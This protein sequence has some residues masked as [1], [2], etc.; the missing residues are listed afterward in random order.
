V[1]ML[2]ACPCPLP[3]VVH[4]LPGN[5]KPVLHGIYIRA[6]PSCCAA[7]LARDRRARG[8]GPRPCLAAPVWK[9]GDRVDARVDMSARHALARHCQRKP[10]AC[11][12]A[13]CAARAGLRT[14]C[15]QRV[16]VHP[17]Q[18]ARQ[19]REP[20]LPGLKLWPPEGE[21]HH[22]CGGAGE[23]CA[24]NKPGVRTSQRRSRANQRRAP[25]P[26]AHGDRCAPRDHVPATKAASVASAARKSPMLGY[27]DHSL[28]TVPADVTGRP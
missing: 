24:N 17:R 14:L 15:R 18:P 6:I 9:L 1:H 25:A 16:S 22:R 13:A 2:C 20:N 10:A 28:S 19:R 12:A 8:R 4:A 21:Q 7:T 5:R 23:A 26:R 11:T 27:R 3:T